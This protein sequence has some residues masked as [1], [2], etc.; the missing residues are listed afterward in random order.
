[1]KKYLSLILAIVMV[2]MV[3]C[4]AMP[5]AVAAADDYEIEFN[6]EKM[7]FADLHMGD[8]AWIKITA[9]TEDVNIKLLKDVNTDSFKGSYFPLYAQ[10]LKADNTPVK[11][12]F[13]GNGY[14]ITTNANNFFRLGGLSGAPTAT[15]NVTFKNL[16]IEYSG[17]GSVLQVYSGG[18]F[19]IENVIMN[20]SSQ[21]NWTAFNA[22][23]GD[24]GLANPAN[25]T[26]TNVEINMGPDASS[27]STYTTSCIRTGNTSLKDSDG[28]GISDQDNGPVVNYTFNNCFFNAP[29]TPAQVD[30]ADKAGVRAVDIT[31]GRS[32]IVAN[33][34]T[35][36]SPNAPIYGN[37]SYFA[38]KNKVTE[39]IRPGE[40]WATLNDCVLDNSGKNSACKADPI[41]MED[42]VTETDDPAVENGYKKFEMVKPGESG[43]LPE[44][45]TDV[46]AE[47]YLTGTDTPVIQVMRKDFTANF[48]NGGGDLLSSDPRVQGAD[49]TIEILRDINIGTN[50]CRFW[51]TLGK[52]IT[53]NG[54]GHKV[55]AATAG[56]PAFRYNSSTGGGAVV[57]N[58]LDIHE[59]DGSLM[60]FYNGVEVTLNNCDWVS[61]AHMGAY[62]TNSGTLNL[63]NST[64]TTGSHTIN[65]QSNNVNGNIINVDENSALICTGSGKTINLAKSE[66]TQIYIEGE[67][68]HTGE[69]GVAVF[70][71]EGL[72]TNNVFAVNQKTEEAVTA[73]AIEGITVVEIEKEVGETTPNEG[74]ETTPDEGDETTPDQGGEGD[75]TTPNQGGEGDQTTPNQGGEGD[76]TTPNQ[77]GEGDQTTAKPDENKGGACGG[78]AIAAQ[79]AALIFAAAAVMIIKKK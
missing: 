39:A 14:T 47:F 22:N 15:N 26:L 30:G 57:I 55:E 63:V 60:Q 52:T 44:L 50:Q 8:M 49:V 40:D 45:D 17:A 59:T 56:N 18:E 21:I 33:G 25:V 42:L 6:G 9:A 10:Y 3:F 11:F 58:D 78:I 31:S 61:D 73:G 24:N 35:F 48:S 70:Q 4:A 76:Q 51:A 71:A 64:L 68:K 66:F 43:K 23:M 12:V 5:F 54:N 38:S 36:I 28:D 41:Y 37:S 16:N 19:A 69:N 7:N 72:M 62:L 20:I 65:G 67:V 1:M 74:D 27:G 79:L 34:C 2:A 77:G 13:D 53:V 32:K 29:G 46:V 75:Q